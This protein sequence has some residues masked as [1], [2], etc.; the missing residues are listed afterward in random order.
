MTSKP[1]HDITCTS[2]SKIFVWV[3]DDLSAQ[4]GSRASTG[5]H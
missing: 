2:D 5:D 1:W 4:L 3:S